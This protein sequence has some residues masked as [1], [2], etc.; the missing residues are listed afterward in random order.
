MRPNEAV[1]K[2]TKSG[3]KSPARK[4]RILVADDHDLVQQGLRAL[5]GQEPNWKVCGVAES[6]PEAVKQA[7]RLRPDVAVVDL[8]LPGF[9]GLE[10]TR[11]L[12]ERLPGCEILIFT[13]RSE[14]DAAIREVFASGAKS[15]ILKTE[16]AN[17]LVEAIAHLG[18]HKPY[19]TETVSAIL[20]ARFSPARKRRAHDEAP[21]DERLS[22][23]EQS[24]VR[25]L[26]DGHSNASVAKKQGLSVRTVENTRAAI[27]SRLGLASFADLVRY[28]VRNGL[29]KV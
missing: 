6:G 22:P 21:G 26:A 23:G 19:F 15:Y 12:K 11:R 9:G 4:L 14:P 29:V 8:D 28:A 16:V 1:P 2:G 18:Q 17:C 25:L 5:I 20:F 24:V 7:L 10:V 3:A 13:G 27:M